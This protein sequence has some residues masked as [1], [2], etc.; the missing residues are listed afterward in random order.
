MI[1]H[2]SNLKEF[3]IKKMMIGVPTT[4]IKNGNMEKKKKKKT[5]RKM[6]NKKKKKKK[7]RL[8]LLSLHTFLRMVDSPGRALHSR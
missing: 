2:S 7:K 5:K 4:P 8:S 6:K 3:V 1:Q